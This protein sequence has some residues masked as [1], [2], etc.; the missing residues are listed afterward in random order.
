MSTTIKKFT[1]SD[2]EMVLTLESA[3]EGGFVVTSPLD[4]ELVTEAETLDED[5]EN[6]KD[7]AEALKESRQKLIRHL[8]GELS[9]EEAMGL[10]KQNS[11]RYAKRQFTWFQNQLEG[12]FFVDSRSIIAQFKNDYANFEQ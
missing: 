11:R 9:I 10:I 8:D 5:F 3:E 7:A 12:E 1:V 6:A 4:P 2:G